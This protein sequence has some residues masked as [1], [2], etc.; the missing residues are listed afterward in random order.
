MKN[1]A[2]AIEATKAGQLDRMSDQP[3]VVEKKAM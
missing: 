3:M 2:N 1:I